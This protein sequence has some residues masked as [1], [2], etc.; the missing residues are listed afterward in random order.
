M[1]APCCYVKSSLQVPYG[2]VQL[3]VN[4]IPTEWVEGETLVFDDSFIHSV[5]HTGSLDLTCTRAVLIADLWHPQVT[6]A[7]RSTI[8]YMFSS[9][10][11]SGSIATTDNS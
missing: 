1:S 8:N 5:K 9:R 6:L 4:Y 3:T 2:C 7:E 10:Q 11:N